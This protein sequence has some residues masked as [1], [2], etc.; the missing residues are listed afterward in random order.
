MKAIVVMLLLALVSG[1]ASASAQVTE[2]REILSTGQVQGAP[3]SS[4]KADVLYFAGEM[5]AKETYTLTIKGPASITLFSRQ[6]IEILSAEGSGTVRL[7]AIL[8]GTDVYTLAIARKVPAQS[9]TLSRRATVPTL[10]EALLAQGVGF[11]GTMSDGSDVDLCWIIPGLKAR[12]T[13]PKL[14]EEITLAADRNT[15]L[16]VAKKAAGTS[17]G[18]VT[19]R[20]VGADYERVVKADDGREGKGAYPFDP[21]P[22]VKK[23]QRAGN[24]F[25][26]P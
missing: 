14:V 19:Y 17:T 9:Y 24:Y 10:A 1:A 2:A 12:R 22:E 4:A 15:V 26:K 23:E 11:T 5:G 6:G 18:Q 7:E 21:I 16:F 20:I 13:Y 25:C 3:G 8:P